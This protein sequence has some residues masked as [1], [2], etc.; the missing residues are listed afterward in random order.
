MA[1][2]LEFPRKG[3]GDMDIVHVSFNYSV[4]DEPGN[5]DY[6]CKVSLE[7][8]DIGGRMRHLAGKLEKAERAKL[9][10]VQDIYEGRIGPIRLYLMWRVC[11]FLG[12]SGLRKPKA[13]RIRDK[14][15]AITEQ[16]VR[17]SPPNFNLKIFDEGCSREPRLG[18]RLRILRLLKG[19]EGFSFETRRTDI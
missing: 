12:L 16:V 2:M 8:R 4:P 3:V 14:A 7:F 9:K 10:K 13:E 11:D 19:A 1:R 15:R 5:P 17:D 6:S 18:R